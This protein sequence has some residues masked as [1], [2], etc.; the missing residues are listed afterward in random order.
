MMNK[1]FVSKILFAAVLLFALAAPLAAQQNPFA[2]N[3]LR[4]AA[5]KDDAVKTAIAAISPRPLN[6]E[7][8]WFAAERAKKSPNDLKR[9]TA[10]TYQRPAR[11]QRAQ[12]FADRTIGP[13]TLLGIAVGAGFA[14]RSDTPEDWENDSKGYARR[15]GSAFGENAIEQTIVFG[16][17]ETFRVD[18]Q[19]YKKGKGTK[20]SARFANAILTTI[21]AR[22]PSGRRVPGF[23][24][25]A[26]VYA[27]NVIS[28]T[29][30]Y[31]KRFS[32]QDGLRQGTIQ[33]GF[34]AAFNLLREF[35]FPGR[36]K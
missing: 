25:V 28:T 30:W 21:T 34:D 11:K 16:L 32:Y 31:P 1:P 27:S 6:N 17:D 3:P 9:Q 14:H 19:F 22:T 35:V 29:T 2:S 36:K 15:F 7:F 24:R 4:R 18:S 33:L 5:I 23:S 8:S 13:F 26:G 10:W 12:K 20:T